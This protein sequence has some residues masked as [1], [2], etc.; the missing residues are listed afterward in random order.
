MVSDGRD[1]D[2]V[3]DIHAEARM[4]GPFVACLSVGVAD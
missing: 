3:L 2:N 1:S 4:S